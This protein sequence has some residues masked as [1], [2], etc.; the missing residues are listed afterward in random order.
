MRVEVPLDAMPQLRRVLGEL[1][2]PYS[3]LELVDAGWQ[4]YVMAP[5]TPELVAR[6][7]AAGARVAP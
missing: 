1:Q 6:L 7:Q 4:V 2:V 5:R 3:L